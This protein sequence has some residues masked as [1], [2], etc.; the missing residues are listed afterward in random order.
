MKIL[1]ITPKRLICG[2]EASYNYMFPLGLGYISATLKV[3]GHAVDCLNLNHCAG[4]LDTI[5]ENHFHEHGDYDF[6]CT[7]GLSTNFAQV[8]RVVQC[9]RKCAGKARIILGGGLISSEPTLM[10]EALRPD[11]VVVGEGEDTI[12]EFMEAVQQGGDLSRVAGLGFMD[13][14]HNLAFTPPR[15]PIMDLDALPWPDFEGFDFDD[16][17]N[18]QKPTDLYFYDIYDQPRVYPIATSRSCPYVCTFCFHPLGNTYRQRSISSVME[19][20]ETNVRRYRINIIAIYDELFSHRT[21]RVIEFCSRMKQL[22]SQLPWECSWGC[23]MRVDGVSGE[24]LSLMRESGCYNVSYGFES[25]SEKV[26]RSMRKH[27]TPAEIEKAVTTTL[28]NNISLQ[29]NFIFGDRAETLTTAN[30]TLSFWKKHPAAGIILTF[31]SPYPGTALYAHCIQKGIIKDKLDFIENH[32]FDTLNMSD[33]MTDDEFETLQVQVYEL[34]VKNCQTAIP[35]KISRKDDGTYSLSVSC[36]HCHEGMTYGN[37]VLPNKHLFNV[38]T[39]CRK[40]RKRFYMVSGAYR[41]IT[42][43]LCIALSLLPMAT[44][45][46]LYRCMERF[47]QWVIAKLMTGKWNGAKIKQMLGMG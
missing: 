20:I 6:V 39:Y 4:P 41:F 17:L 13:S 36:P 32:I 2:E 24:M 28:S 40:C 38:M 44:K 21:E 46:W 22:R 45:R 16:Y 26:L 37:Y 23:Q 27:I 43:S 7:G 47:K 25:C 18:H 19:E 12:K 35:K 14:D 29:G 10:F 31:I 11:F 30:E 15:K 34:S 8:K 9:L 33:E 42:K 3:S 1:V 5:I